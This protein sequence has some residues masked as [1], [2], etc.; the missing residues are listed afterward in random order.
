M[1]NKLPPPPKTTVSES[2][3]ID[4]HFRVTFPLPKEEGWTDWSAENIALYIN[5]LNVHLTYDGNTYI[6]ATRTYSFDNFK[7]ISAPFNL[8]DFD[9]TVSYY[10]ASSYYLTLYIHFADANFKDHNVKEWKATI[11]LAGNIISDYDSKV[12]P[13][14]PERNH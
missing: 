10:N 11:K 2:E 9:D 6:P 4:P 5:N 3:V 14:Q 1:A 7:K 8:K 12:L 13:F